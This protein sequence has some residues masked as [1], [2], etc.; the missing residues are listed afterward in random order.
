VRRERRT[1]TRAEWAA[2]TSSRPVVRR[3]PKPTTPVDDSARPWDNAK[4][5]FDAA[6]YQAPLYIGVEL[7]DKIDI[8]ETSE[9]GPH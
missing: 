9:G 8:N 5:M 7:I 4:R 3:Y 6:T 1:P 2:I